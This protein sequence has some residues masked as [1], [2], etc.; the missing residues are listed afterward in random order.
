MVTMKTINC[1]RCG[2]EVPLR[3]WPRKYCTHCSN[4]VAR[5]R[6]AAYREKKKKAE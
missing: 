2:K 5:E 3:A 6:Q 1:E 4:L